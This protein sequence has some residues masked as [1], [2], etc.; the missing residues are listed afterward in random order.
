MLLLLGG[1]L[2]AAQVGLYPGELL[3]LPAFGQKF[4]RRLALVHGLAV[5]LGHV[6]RPDVLAPQQLPGHLPQEGG[7]PRAVAA[8]DAHVLPAPDVQPQV[9]RQGRLPLG[10]FPGVQ[11]GQGE[12]QHGFPRGDGRVLPKAHQDGLLAVG[13]LRH[14]LPLPFE[15]VLQGLDRLHFLFQQPAPVGVLAGDGV[16]LVFHLLL[17]FLE[18]FLLFALLLPLLAG[19]LLLVG[20]LLQPLLHVLAVAHAGHGPA[21]QGLAPQLLHVED[22]VGGALQQ[23]LIVGDEQHRLGALPDEGL[24]PVQG[25]NVQVVGGLVQQ[26]AVWAA[27]GEQGHAQLHLL[28]AGEG[29]YQPVGVE[30]VQGEAQ[31]LGRRGQLPGGGVQKS[32]GLAAELVGAQLPLLRGHLL[33]EVAQKHPVLLDGA[34]VFHI[35]L[36][37]GGVVEELEQGGFPVALLP[38]DGGLVPGVQGKGEAPQQV[39]QVF[40]HGYGQIAYLQHECVPPLRR[41]KGPVPCRTGPVYPKG[42]RAGANPSKAKEQ[43]QKHKPPNRHRE[44]APGRCPKAFP[45]FRKIGRLIL[46]SFH[47]FACS[48]DRI[49]RPVGFVN[50]IFPRVIDKPPAIPY[51]SPKG[52]KRHGTS[53]AVFDGGPARLGEDHPGQGAGAGDGGH[54]VYA[55]R[56]A[57]VPLWG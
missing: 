14:V 8:D 13:E 9:L 19:Q 18:A 50:V 20:E 11:G 31:P 37:Q 55:G 7:F 57:P 42:K 54:P 21:G 56:V 52:G 30:P 27:Q 51:D 39:P 32:R 25:V 17:D 26:V 4:H 44:P 28:P 15:A 49:A 24:Q 53:H 34:G 45:M 41:E 12:V 3:L 40:L 47:S 35:A 29:L 38:D 43:G 36:Y 23:Q 33:G 16:Q 10:G 2:H 48:E 22:D 5:V 46:T 1:V 6:G